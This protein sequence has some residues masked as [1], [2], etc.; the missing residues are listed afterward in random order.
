M[1]AVRPRAIAAGAIAF[2][3]VAV[4]LAQGSN[5]AGTPANKVAASGSAIEVVGANESKVVLSETVKINNPTDLIIGVTS[6]CAILTEVTNSANG[7]TERAFGEITYSVRIDG[8]TVPVATDA[9]GSGEVVFCNRAQEQQWTDSQDPVNGND[10]GEDSLRQYLDTRTANGFNWLALNVGTNYPGTSDNV[11]K[12]EV[13][14]TWNTTAT[15]GAVAEAAIG[16]R[17]LVLEPVKAAVGEAVT[18]LG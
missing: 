16:N 5:A 15:A 9:P 10:D 14:A 13:V 17:T 6:E 11:H 1:S 4:T 2:G 12:I 7:Q 18:E 3:L 8:I